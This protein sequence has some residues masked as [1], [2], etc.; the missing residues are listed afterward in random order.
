MSFNIFL[1]LAKP[2]LRGRF[3]TKAAKPRRL[4]RRAY[5]RAPGAWILLA[6]LLAALLTPGESGAMSSE[7]EGGRSLFSFE[8]PAS[9]GEW[10]IVNDDVMGGVSTSR[11]R[12]T[13]EGTLLFSGEISLDNN[14]GFASLRSLPRALDLAGGDALHL[15]VRG[16]G[17]DYFVN[18]YV[19]RSRTAF[20]FRADM[21]TEPGQWTELHIPMQRF[22]AR[23]FGRPADDALQPER[24]HSLGFMLSDG[25]PGSFE[26]EVEWVRV[27]SAG[28][29]P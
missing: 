28:T 4:A 27:V 9:A 5:S 15:R 20:S 12:I 16:D 19:P 14:G 24:V 23:W 7:Q 18:L 6:M 8:S 17:R 25:V 2:V 29:E 3:H 13:D 26:L 11:F 10:R 1:L 21:K 22:E